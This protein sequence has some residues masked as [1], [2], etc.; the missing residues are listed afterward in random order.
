MSDSVE[1]KLKLSKRGFAAAI[2]FNF[3]RANWQFQHLSQIT[4]LIGKPV[5]FFFCVPVSLE[6]DN[7]NGSFCVHFWKNFWAVSWNR[8]L[9]KSWNCQ[10]G[11]KELKLAAEAQPRADSFNFFAAESDS[12]NFLA[13]ITVSWNCP[14]ISTFFQKLDTKLAIFICQF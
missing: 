13:N 9:A 7:K 11:C 8:D 14:K 1:K 12:F 4:V 3:F 6:T 10:Y 2:S 5:S